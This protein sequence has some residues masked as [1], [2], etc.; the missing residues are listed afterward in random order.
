M[1]HKKFFLILLIALGLTL[2]ACGAGEEAPETINVGAVVPLTGPFAGGGA[3]VERGYQMAVEDIN[4]AGGIYVEEFDQ[5]IPIELTLLDDES[6]PNST[7]SHLEALNSDH[8]VVAYLGGFGSG[9]HA[10]AAAIAEKNQV[11]YL[12]VAFALEGPHNQGFQYLF[13]PF[14][15]SSDLSDAMFEMVN[16][17]TTEEN[18]PTQV[19]IFQEQTDW[20]I[21]LGTLWRESA[22]EF[23]Y[24]VVVYEEYTP[25]TTDYT[26]LIL[27]AQD[28]GANMVL[29]LPT[30]PDGFT[31]YRQMGELGYTPDFAF[32]V[33]AADVPTWLDLGSVGDYVILAPGWHNA[34]NYPGVDELNAKHMEMMERPADPMVGP[35]YAAVQILADSIERAGSLDRE[36][37]REAIAATD[38]ETMIGPVT[39]R[40]NGTGVVVAPF[41]QYQNGNIELVWPQEFATADLVVPAPPFE[42]R[43]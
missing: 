24:D 1:M 28:A 14:P 37:I 34:M 13:S 39:F 7:V 8:E 26:D 6:D 11:P 38:M 32:M 5:Q 36:A 2:A 3:Q 12:G 33:R 20:G 23:G 15:K 35:A 27:R 41:L 22:E 17:Y 19:A 10:A 42:E 29:A 21:E 18:R 30:P 16:A 4:A 25:G 31:M 43:E 40:E 9:L